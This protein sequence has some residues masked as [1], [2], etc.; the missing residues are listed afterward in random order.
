MHLRAL[1]LVVLIKVVNFV[2]ILKNQSKMRTHSV[3]HSR[4]RLKAID[5][6]KQRFVGIKLEK[7][8]FGEE[9]L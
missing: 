5:R 8:C 3:Y 2:L 6:L 7:V 1:H 9:N 4:S